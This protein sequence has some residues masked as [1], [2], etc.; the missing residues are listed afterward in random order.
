MK[1]IGLISQKKSESNELASITAQLDAGLARKRVWISK[2]VLPIKTIIHAA[3]LILNL[4]VA[5]FIKNVFK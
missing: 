5:T 3:Y 1:V 4:L 2:S